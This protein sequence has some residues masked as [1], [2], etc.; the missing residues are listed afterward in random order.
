ML[1]FCSLVSGSSGNCLFIENDDT[2]LLVDCGI[3]CKRTKELLKTIGVN[4][5]DIDAVLIT[6]EHTDHINGLNIISK[7]YNIPV[8][9][10]PETA[11]AIR[12]KCPEAR[13]I[14]IVNGSFKIKSVEILSFPTPHDVPSCCYS[15]TYDN[16][17]I[18]V[19]TDLGHLTQEI[20]QAFEGCDFA[21]IESNHDVEMLVNGPY[22]YPLKRRI[23]SDYG[24]LSNKICSE[25]IIKLVQGGTKK[26][27]L[28]HLSEEN[29]TPEIALNSAK[30]A[31]EF[32]RMDAD[33]S[34]APRNFPCK[35]INL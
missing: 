23:L 5:E 35:F 7:Y 31:L 12:E 20:M 18:T 27:M 8:Y 28:G 15:F 32:F 9:T 11:R 26:I 4:I 33:V 21:Y 6:H 30:S 19:A 2:K 16:K 14:T 25:F 13:N 17:K 24:H 3:S 10:N 22:P 1:R 34:V 29:N